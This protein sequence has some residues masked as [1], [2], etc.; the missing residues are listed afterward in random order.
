[1]PTATETKQQ[2]SPPP[3]VPDYGEWLDQVN[4]FKNEDDQRYFIWRTLR[5][6]KM[7]PIFGRFFFPHIIKGE[8]DTPACHADLTTELGR[9]VTSAAVFPRG[10]AKTTWEKIDTLHDIVYALEPVIL[11]IGPTMTDSGFHFES[12]KTELENNDELRRVY[13][14][15]VPPNTKRGRKWTNKHIQTTNGVNLVARNRLRGRGVNIKNQRPTK[16]VL[17]DIEDD[18]QVKNQT[19]RTKLS[20]WLREVILPSMDKERGYVKM[21]GTVLHEACEILAFYK[22]FGGIFRKAIEDEAPLWPEMYSLADLETI[23]E[24]IGSVAFAKEYLNEPKSEADARIKREWIDQAHYS[25][26]PEDALYQAVITLDPQ[27]GESQSADEYALTCLYSKKR[28]PHRYCFEQ[29]AGHASQFDQAKAVVRMWVRHKKLVRAV[30]I[31]KVMNQ[32]AA[33]QNLMDWKTGKINFNTKEMTEEYEATGE[34][35]A[36][37]V[38]ED[39]R[40]IPIVIMTPEK[41]KG[42]R[43]DVFAADFERGEIHLRPEQEKLRDQLMYMGTDE[44]DHDDRADGLVAALELAGQ[45]GLR[46][47]E[48]EK[49]TP[50]E[51]AKAIREKEAIKARSRSFAGN[52]RAKR[53]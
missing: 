33:W 44:L 16:A 38:D 40:N 3:S 45:F 42:A 15:L 23:R 14:D 2:P 6:K 41:D 4:A 37:W 22:E 39:D 5:D 29:E 36:H 7:L 26:L 49:L 20:K 32:T 35:P 30:G 48:T 8:Y 52:V 34:K 51:E 17:D 21:I 25:Q 47:K 1:M 18:E 12:I 9:R 53:W 24:R 13:G 27:S 31:E 19:R 28:T 10:H 46:Q 11:Y 50:E 43:L